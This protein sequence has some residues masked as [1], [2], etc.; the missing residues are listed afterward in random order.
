MSWD[1]ALSV[2][3]LQKSAVQGYNKVQYCLR[4]CYDRDMEVA[5]DDKLAIEWYRNNRLGTQKSTIQT[6]I[7][8]AKQQQWRLINPTKPRLYFPNLQ[9]KIC[10]TLEQLLG[11]CKSNTKTK[12]KKKR[13]TTCWQVLINIWTECSVFL[14]CVQKNY[15]KI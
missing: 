12:K 5:Q 15:T 9:K 2:E 6:L 11:C 10:P 3:W 8:N 14:W 7:Q 4:V 13:K 1:L